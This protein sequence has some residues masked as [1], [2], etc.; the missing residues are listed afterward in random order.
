M[1]QVNVMNILHTLDKK[2]L[3]HNDTKPYYNHDI[4][5][6]IINMCMLEFKKK[7]NK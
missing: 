6:N 1:N 4:R 3:L 7:K 2:M 5:V